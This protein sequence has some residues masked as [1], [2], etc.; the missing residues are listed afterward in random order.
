M[1]G[2]TRRDRGPFRRT[3]VGAT[4]PVMDNMWGVVADERGALADDL[5]SLDD[6]SWDLPSLCKEWTVRDTVAH[7]IST[8][9]MTPPKFLGKMLTNRFG[10]QRLVAKD[11]A[12]NRGANSAATLQHLRAV[13]DRRTSPPG[14]KTAWLGETI[15][16]AED[17][18]RP[19]GLARE[20]P[21]DAL[22][23]V[24]DFYKGSDTLIGTKTRIAGLALKATD[25]EWSHGSGPAVEGPMLSLLLAMT[26]RRDALD[27]LSGDGVETM[28]EHCAS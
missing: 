1:Y 15:V 27:D 2:V 8:A 12:T 19:L 4:L 7:M 25:T 10:F 3:G 6:A 16:H 21:M 20:Y 22:V 17:V 26:G 11:I 9:E 23:T 14:P 13:R 28:R 5:A 24:A 18:R